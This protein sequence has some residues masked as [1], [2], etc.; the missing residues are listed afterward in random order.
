MDF[1][2]YL[3]NSMIILEKIET[4]TKLNIF[5]KEIKRVELEYKFFLNIN[6]NNYL[7]LAILLRDKLKEFILKGDLPDTKD[8][9]YLYIIFDDV[10]IAK[11]D[12]F[13]GQSKLLS[14]HLK[15]LDNKSSEWSLIHNLIFVF[16]IVNGNTKDGLKKYL[17]EVMKINIYSKMDMNI[18]TFLEDINIKFD[19]IYH[20]LKYIFSKEFF[21]SLNGFEQRSICLWT[22]HSIYNIKQFYSPQ[23]FAKLFPEWKAILFG[24]LIANNIDMALY[25][26]FFMYHFMGNSYT[27]NLEWKVMNDEINIPSSKYYKKWIDRANLKKAKTK[28]SENGKI[29]IG[30]LM[31]RVTRNSQFK[32]EYSIFKSLMQNDEFKS[33]YEITVYSAG[34][35]EKG[36]DDKDCV[37][38]INSLGIVVINAGY[39]E[40]LKHGMYNNHLLRAIKI[41]DKIINDEID[42]LFTNMNGH[43]INIFL[44]ISR[45]AP[46]QI[47]FGH[48]EMFFDIEGIDDRLTMA[49]IKGFRESMI[50]GFHFYEYQNIIDTEFL[51]PKLSKQDEEY[52]K[53]LKL[54]YDDK[55]ILGTIG[56]LIKLANRDYLKIVLEVLKE[57]ENTV[58]LACGAGGEERVKELLEELNKDI[59][60]SNL[61]ERF[62]F[63]GLINPNIYGHII[64]LFLNT[65][66]I[67]QGLSMIEIGLK[68]KPIISL[69]IEEWG[70]AMNFLSK[71]CVLFT[72]D[73]Y[74]KLTL[75]L[76]DNVNLYQIYSN[77][78]Y[79]TTLDYI[80]YNGTSNALSSILNIVKERYKKC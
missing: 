51:N 31:D 7:E 21:F 5:I 2:T 42:I 25:F 64:D 44:L 48:G 17:S 34:Y 62:I 80:D 28:L 6:K 3:K 26:Q 58:Y 10:K 36:D 57:R 24:Y 20:I 70:E 12:L 54:K 60:I 8:A 50:E 33:K 71:D 69:F 67:S 46:I 19:E 63:T 15:S 49:S 32:V 65:F 13:E 27:E 73:D 45:I 56:R 55:F 37:E 1:N 52:I 53:H 14:E 41:R 43:G 77:N 59:K 76:I 68:S 72:I 35:I 29:K 22:I 75:E 74:K 16:D 78:T 23:H 9:I 30:F 61:D 18:E 4:I 38:M 47:Y 11:D 40:F 39:D 79:N 66:P